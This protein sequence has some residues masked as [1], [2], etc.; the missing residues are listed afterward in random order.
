MGLA[1][2]DWS[3]QEFGIAA[4]LS[5]DPAMVAAYQTG[6]PYLAFAVQAGVAPGG[7]TKESHKKV[8]EQFKQCALGV[9]YGMGEDA[10][11]IRA[12]CS[13]AEARELLSLHRRTYPRYWRWSQ[14]A[15]DHAMLRGFLQATF[16]WTVRT[17]PD[18]KP[19]TL[20]NFPM[21]AN[22]AE[23]LRLA[24]IIA[25]ESSVRV[26]AP[27]HDALLIEATLQGLPA[28]VAATQEAMAAASRAVLVNLELRS[29]VKLVRYPDRYM[30]ER[31]IAMWTKVWTC[32]EA[33]TGRRVP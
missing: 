3:Q 25:V 30:D 2:V 10:L 4:A 16:G 28:A 7:A 31:G 9:L 21:Q 6:D 29:D 23:M 11:A 24:C 15:V 14:A 18:T 33:L 8:R 26:C 12:G 5:A 1:Y 19:R 17:G 22:G 32:I 20:S 13:S 27:V